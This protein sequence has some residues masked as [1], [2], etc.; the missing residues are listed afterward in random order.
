M[1]LLSALGSLVLA[2]AALFISGCGGGGGGG[3]A[4]PATTVVSGVVSKGSVGGAV[5]KV[6]AIN[7]DGTKGSQL[8]P[9][10]GVESSNGTDGRRKGAYA[11][12]L[13]SYNGPILVEATGGTYT[14]EAT[15]AVRDLIGITLRAAS[16][17][18]V[19]G[20]NPVMV[21][22]LT[23]VAVQR[24]AD[25]QTASII[26]ANNAVAQLFS[27]DNIVTTEPIDSNSAG[28]AGASAAVKNYALA[29]ATVSQYIENKPGSGLSNAITDFKNALDPATPAATVSQTLASV[30]AAQANVLADPLVNSTGLGAPIAANTTATIRM[31]T[32]GTLPV[33]TNI[34]GVSLNIILPAGV[35]VPVDVNNQILTANLVESGVAATTVGSTQVIAGSFTAA[36]AA[37]SPAK[38]TIGLANTVGFLTGEFARLT[39]NVAAQSRVIPSS[40][41]VT[42]AIVTDVSGNPVGSIKVELTVTIP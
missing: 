27:V 16:T 1:K 20:V 7:P 30:V 29:L 5:V 6:F 37:T 13:G 18:V 34:G 8:G 23:E 10:A 17:S 21:T 19:T 11:I 28:A 31:K 40:F 3:A 41:F 24:M 12:D 33:G 25:F 2:T 32:V 14:D 36:V 22:P 15:Q 4:P 39:C 9:V 26:N 38:V 35:T 42:D